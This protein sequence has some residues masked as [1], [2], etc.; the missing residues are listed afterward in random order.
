MTKLAKWLL[1]S[2]PDVREVHRKGKLSKRLREALGDPETELEI[3]RALREGT[4]AKIEFE[5]ETH[6]ITRRSNPSH[7]N[8]RGRKK[9]TAGG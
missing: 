2:G 7:S 6:I 1:L 4:G 8:G 5:G 9:E 3:S